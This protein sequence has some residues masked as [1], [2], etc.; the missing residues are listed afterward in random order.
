MPKPIT[1]AE[2]R[3]PDAHLLCYKAR[4]ATN[5]IVQE[6]CGPAVPGDRGT[7]IDPRQDKHQKL[8]GVYVANQFGEE[9]YDTVKEIELCV[10]SALLGG[11]PP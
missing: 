11:S 6:G 7:R 3:N 9:R 2:T 4:L 1:P 10:P 8:T 5:H